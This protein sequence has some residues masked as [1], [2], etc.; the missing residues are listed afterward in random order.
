MKKFL[1]FVKKEFY[2][3]FR[4]FR[5]LLILFG[6]P[7]AQVLIFGF[8][9][10]TEIKDAKIA[11]LDLSKD[12]ITEEISN[13][14]I[15]SNY[16]ILERNLESYKQIEEEFKKGSIK[17]VIVFEPEFAKKLEKEYKANIQII[18]DASDPNL[19]NMLINYT[20][21]IIMDYLRGM[22]TY[23]NNFPTIDT[24]IKMIYNPEL[25]SVFK[26]V[27]GLMAVI[28]LLISALMTSVSITREKE[29]GTMEVLLVSPLSPFQ[30]IVGK[31]IPYIFIAFIDAGIILYLAKFVFK[32]P[33][34]GSLIL[35]I[36]QCVL[37]VIT[38]LSL[39]IL[40]STL[41]NNQQIAMML[42]LAALLLPTV[43]LSGYIF[44]VENMP[45]A[46]QWISNFI[47]ARWFIIIVKSIM[48]KG[49]NI[50]YI[51]EESLILLIMCLFFIIV[52]LRRFKIRLE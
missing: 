38:A 20:T 13:K 12:N 32:M 42:S 40:I 28:L 5:T 35:L 10:T 30:I 45:E 16:F 3:I 25:K 49:S 39:G 9:I 4:D 8:A 50:T 44:P 34:E 22:E 51:W 26:F 29:F 33:F 37:Y 47:P 15:S 41:T 24:E 19:A 21:A 31:V 27:P 2:H 7:I 23:P 18:A 1:G 52:S 43:L 17:A 6:I 14:I 36:L 46:L 48:L 11:F